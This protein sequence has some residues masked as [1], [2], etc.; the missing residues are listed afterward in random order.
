MNYK[1][2]ILPFIAI[3]LIFIY[4]INLDKENKPKESYLLPKNTSIHALS[5]KSKDLNF[6]LEKKG[7]NWFITTPEKWKAD[8]DEIANLVDSLLNTKIIASVDKYTDNNTYELSDQKF[9]SV[10]NS[11]KYNILIGKRD[12]S[13]KM[14]YVTLEDEGEV[15][16]VSANFLNYLPSTL[17][18]IKDKT[19]YR[20]SKKGLKDFELKIDNKSYTFSFKN[21]HY[22]LNNKKL[23]DN[24]SSSLINK[25]SHLEANTFAN[26][27]SLDNATTVGYIKYIIDNKTNQFNIYKNKENDYLISIDNKSSVFKIYNYKLDSFIKQF[28][29]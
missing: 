27:K 11:E 16:L 3:L 2:F 6:R 14:V 24:V 23:T 17:N 13:Y 15:K 5:Y 10:E 20:F 21:N 12:S 22:Y 26:E 19:I 1:N 8:K 28:N 18:Q 29:L 25:I 4:V 9:L 7:D